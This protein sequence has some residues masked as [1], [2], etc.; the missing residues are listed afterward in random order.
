MK[1]AQADMVSVIIIVA[2]S[3]ALASVAYFWGFPLIQ[4]RQDTALVERVDGYFSQDNGNSLPIIIENVANSGGEKTFYAN[5]KGLWILNDSSKG[6]NYIQFTFMAKASKF[7]V[8]SAYPISLTK[9][10]QCS[11]PIE[12]GTIG[13]DKASIVCVQSNKFGDSINVTYKIFFRDLYEN[14]YSAGGRGYRI[15][16]KADP[17]GFEMSKEK[18]I[19]ISY[20]GVRQETVN[21]KTLIIKEIKILLI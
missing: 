16:L 4:K 8:D 7:A 19:K 2:I 3:L 15:E 6:G 18:S 11:Q 20:T 1:K 9:G 17:S 10:A 21:E 5:V 12:N 14:A 13:I